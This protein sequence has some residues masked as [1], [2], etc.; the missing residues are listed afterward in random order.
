MAGGAH[1]IVQMLYVMIG[2]VVVVGGW[3]TRIELHDQQTTDHFAAIETRHA[4]KSSEWA[5]VRE[6]LKA[7]HAD[8]V[9]IKLR[10]MALGVKVDLLN[11]NK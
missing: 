7:L 1:A 3:L 5:Q 10:V 6:E 8:N 4:E 11:G 2:L 9:D